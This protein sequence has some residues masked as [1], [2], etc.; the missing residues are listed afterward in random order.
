MLVVVLFFERGAVHMNSFKGNE[1]FLRCPAIVVKNSQNIVEFDA[2][3]L[4]V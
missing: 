2:F 4:V 3:S 1:V